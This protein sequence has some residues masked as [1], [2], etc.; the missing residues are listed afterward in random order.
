MKLKNPQIVGFGISNNET[1]T[2]ATKYTKGAIIGSAFVKH[3]TNEGIQRIGT[4]VKKIL[5]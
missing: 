4:F 5:I 2:Q 3:V 1:F